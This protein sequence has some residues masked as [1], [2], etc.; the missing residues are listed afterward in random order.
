MLYGTMAQ[1]AF[2]TVEQDFGYQPL[3]TSKENLFTGLQI[4]GVRK[5]MIWLEDFN[6]NV[7]SLVSGGFPNFY[8]R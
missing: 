5:E 1:A 4:L 8:I 2:P 3:R 6:S 7:G